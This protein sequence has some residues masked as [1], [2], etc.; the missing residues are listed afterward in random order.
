MLEPKDISS[1]TS[2]FDLG[3]KP[4]HEEIH[5]QTCFHPLKTLNLSPKRKQQEK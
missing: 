2:F 4:F 5:L 3:A 1:I